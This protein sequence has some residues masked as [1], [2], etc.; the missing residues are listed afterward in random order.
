MSRV[1]LQSLIIRLTRYEVA[2]SKL[3]TMR[4][5]KCRAS[6]D[7]HQPNPLQPD[8]FLGT[9]SSCG[10]WY[11]ILSQADGGPAS[12]VQLPELSEFPLA[13]VEHHRN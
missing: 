3:T 11:R 12:V 7:L 4:C 2:A 8:Q 9:C 5:R 1:S 10:S 13:G 6:V